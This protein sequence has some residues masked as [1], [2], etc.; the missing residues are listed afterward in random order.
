MYLMSMVIFHCWRLVDKSPSFL[1]LLCEPCHLT[2]HL[3]QVPQIEVN[4]IPVVF[5][6]A[7]VGTFIVA[8]HLGANTCL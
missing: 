8:D 7:R 6:A 5:S 2:K 4:S 1:L 3:F